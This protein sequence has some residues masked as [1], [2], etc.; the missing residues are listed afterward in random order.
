MKILIAIM[1][2]I[3][4]VLFFTLNRENLEE[5]PHE[6]HQEGV[7]HLSDEQIQAAGIQL[8]S[9]ASRTLEP[10]LKKSAK[11]SFHPDRIVH[12]LTTERGKA[13]KAYKNVGDPVKKGEALARIQSQAIG[14][15][16]TAFLLA[17]NKHKKAKE[18][19]ER[20]QELFEKKILSIDDF[21]TLETDHFEAAAQLEMAK[22]ELFSLGLTLKEILAIEETSPADLQTLTIRAPI[23]GIILERHLTLGENIDTTEPI[24]VIAN[25]SKLWVEIPFFPSELSAVHRGQKVRIQGIETPLISLIPQVGQESYLAK[26]IAAIDNPHGQL[27]PGALIAVEI[28]LENHPATVA[29]EKQAVQ[30]LDGKPHVFIETQEGFMPREVTLGVEDSRFVEVVAGLDP[31]EKYTAKQAFI[32][33]ADLGKE[34]IEHDD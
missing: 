27:L 9:A 2:V 29:I 28:V 24:F 14:E 5:H 26:G 16:K 34:D 6:H 11:I 10:T 7:V 15:K 18:A 23:N 13:K 32:L 19:F 1:A 3:I 4:A 30:M 31:G 17:L 33:K 22:Q 20:N 25:L 8:E 12:V 21:R